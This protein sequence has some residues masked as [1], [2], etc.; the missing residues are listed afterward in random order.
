MFNGFQIIRV[1]DIYPRKENAAGLEVQVH[2]VECNSTLQVTMDVAKSD[3]APN[4]LDAKIG[5]VGLSDRL[6]YSFVLS[7]AAFEVTFRLLP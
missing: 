5:K 7:D 6:V 1:V 2:E 3:L 4:I